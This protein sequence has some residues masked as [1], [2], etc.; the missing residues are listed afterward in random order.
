[1]S[2]FVDKTTNEV[3]SDDDFKGFEFNVGRPTSHILTNLEQASELMNM[4][5]LMSTI[6]YQDLIY[7][8]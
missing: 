3:F 5:S 2:W 1:M 8:F 7:R 4:F 6:S